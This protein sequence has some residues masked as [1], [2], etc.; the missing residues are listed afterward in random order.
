MEEQK[1]PQ[2][3]EPNVS[4]AEDCS[5]V[6]VHTIMQSLSVLNSGVVALLKWSRSFKLVL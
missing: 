2:A 6:G 3:V 4:T 1:P 5:C